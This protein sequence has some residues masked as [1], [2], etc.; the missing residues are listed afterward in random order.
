MASQIWR[1]AAKARHHFNIYASSCVRLAKCS[2][3]GPVG[4]L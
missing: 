3:D 2:G 4:V 1:S